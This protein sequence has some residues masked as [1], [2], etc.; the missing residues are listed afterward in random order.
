MHPEFEFNRIVF[1]LRHPWRFRILSFF[2][3]I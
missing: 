3:V 2:G 1:R